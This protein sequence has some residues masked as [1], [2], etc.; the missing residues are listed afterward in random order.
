LYDS[1]NRTFDLGEGARALHGQLLQLYTAV[2]AADAGPTSQQA[3]QADALLQE[4]DSR[5][6]P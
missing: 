6:R 2:Q 3:A 5:D 4:V 1:I